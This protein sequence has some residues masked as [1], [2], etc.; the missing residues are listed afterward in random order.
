MGVCVCLCMFGAA[1]CFSPCC[2]VYPARL[3][4]AGLVLK[5]CHQDASASFSPYTLLLLLRSLNTAALMIE[6]VFVGVCVQ[7]FEVLFL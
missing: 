1:W 7:V 2:N 5:N 3:Q 6:L 4:V